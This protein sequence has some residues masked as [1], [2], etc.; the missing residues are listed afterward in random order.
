VI[1]RV[2]RWELDHDPAL[3]ARCYAQYVEASPCDCIFCRNVRAAADR[4]YPPLFLKLTQL[5]GID[6]SKPSELCH[7]GELGKACSTHGWFHIVGTVVSGRDAWRQTSSTSW[8]G[9]LETYL[10]V[11]G[12]GFTSKLALVPKV[13]TGHSVVQLEF[14]TIVPWVLAD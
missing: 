10:D 1:T 4:A 8:A 5:L 9:D 11:A 6:W 13:F 12:L 14:Q 2:A 7:Y 3:T